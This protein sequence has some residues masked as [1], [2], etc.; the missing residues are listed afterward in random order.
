MELY[1]KTSSVKKRL[2]YFGLLPKSGANWRIQ[3][4]DSLFFNTLQ[5]VLYEVAPDLLRSYFVF[6]SKI[7]CKVTVDS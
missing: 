1:D 2:C 6:L 4:C 7:V 3:K 5:F